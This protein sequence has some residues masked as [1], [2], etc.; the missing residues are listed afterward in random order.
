MYSAREASQRRRADDLARGQRDFQIDALRRAAAEERAAGRHPQVVSLLGDALALDPSSPR[1][2]RDL[3]V[4][5]LTAG[6][7]A[8]AVPQLD[9]AQRADPTTDGARLLAEAH[10]AAGNLA[11]SQAAT[12][13]H[14]RLAGRDARD[15]VARLTGGPSSP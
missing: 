15:R 2:R 7:A 11:A 4:A 10:A 1:G 3:G 5:L 6:R 13:E 12:A 8:A 14:A 9:V